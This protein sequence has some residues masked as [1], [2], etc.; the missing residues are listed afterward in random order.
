LDRSCEGYRKLARAVL[1]A[2]VKAL[3]ATLARHKG[4]P[5]ESPP[6]PQIGPT[7]TPATGDTLQ[8]AFEGWKRQRERPPATARLKL[9]AALCA[10]GREK[11][12]EIAVRVQGVPHA[13]NR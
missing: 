10:G 2:F 9:L 13:I 7:I 11:H 4:E 8:A 6:L 1:G 3:R 5:I 12:G